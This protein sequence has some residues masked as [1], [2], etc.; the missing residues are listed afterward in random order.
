MVKFK[1]QSMSSLTQA[2]H[3][4]QSVPTYLI[5]NAFDAHASTATAVAA[6]RFKGDANLKSNA[7]C[8]TYTPANSV[9]ELCQHAYVQNSI[10]DN[11]CSYSNSYFV[12]SSDKRIPSDGVIKECSKSSG[13]EVCVPDGTVALACNP[14]SINVGLN[15]GGGNFQL[16]P[17]FIAVPKSEV[18]HIVENLNSC[19][20]PHQQSSGQQRFAYVKT[21]MHTSL[22]DNNRPSQT[23]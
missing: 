13:N 12:N 22:N 19:Y 16:E 11:N 7:I 20:G 15:F 6:S 5:P 1:S 14:D 21:S 9:A 17:S 2:V 10:G 8:V 3:T 18:N 23:F 4:I